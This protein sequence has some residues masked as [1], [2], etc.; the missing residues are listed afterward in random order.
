MGAIVIRPGS[1]IEICDGG[2][3]V[4]ELN[5]IFGN[6]NSD[7]YKYAQAHNKF[8]DVGGALGNYRD[9]IAAYEYARVPVSPAWGAYLRLLGTLVP[10]GPQNIYDIAQFRNQ[11][12]VSGDAMQTIT[13]TPVHGGHVRTQHG[14]KAG[15]ANQVDSPFPLSGAAE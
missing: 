2:D 6:P 7:R 11:Y 10:Q 13:H 9:L 8:G 4:K 14:S 15:L 5:D 12:L 3:V 1:G